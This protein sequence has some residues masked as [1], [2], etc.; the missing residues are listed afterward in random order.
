MG[1]LEEKSKEKRQDLQKFILEA[2]SAAGVLTIG[3]ITPN[4]LLS[5]KKV[6]IIPKP[7]QKEYI[8]SSAS[9]LAR[10]GLLYFDGKRYQM[11]SLGENI[12]RRW[13][14]SDFKIKKP[15]KWDRKWRVIIFDIPEKKR[16]KREQIRRLFLQAGLERL[17]DSVWVYPYD[18]EDV[19]TLL[20]T[21]LGISKNLLYL[22]VDEIENDK[23][24]REIFDL[25]R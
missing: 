7:R 17:Q 3:A 15:K 11:T 24:L 13:Q 19:L 5:L 25:P 16:G 4:V 21:D 14:F 6:G 9:K 18:C 20:K 22:I 10:K 8:G 2:V 1:K 12:L 23:Y